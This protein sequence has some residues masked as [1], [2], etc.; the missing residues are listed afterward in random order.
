MDLG[1][2]GRVALVTGASKGLGF[3]IASALAREGARVAIS[4][5]SP[6]RIE[7]A[8]S[9][10]GVK[11]LAHDAADIGGV[12]K[13]T[14]QVTEQLGPIDILVTN[15][16][17]P[18]ASPDALSFTQAD[19][20][21]AY[22]MLLLGQIALIEAALPGMRERRW[23]RVL[24]ISSSVVREPSANLVLSSAHRSGL[25]AALKTIARQVAP[26]G[27]TINT[28]LPG[29]ILTDR[30]RALGVDTPG[31]AAAIPAGRLGTVEE[32]AAA[33]AFLCSEQASYIT[34]TTVL[35]DGGAG[36]AV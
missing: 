20:R 26:D 12:Q 6:E 13:L 10:I 19:W 29:L 23:G 30:T 25:L 3:G 17:G 35:V 9:A 27:V 33:A 18:P 4:S 14:Q 7:A 1:I 24:S 36:R 15:S 34:G 31:A 32:F 16:G 21:A 5:R 28:L 11:A 2:E 22:E 8:A